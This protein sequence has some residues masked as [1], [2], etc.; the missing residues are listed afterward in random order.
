MKNLR[1]KFQTQRPYTVRFFPGAIPAPQKS[2]FLLID[3]GSQIRAK[4]NFY[5]L[6]GGER[7]KSW[8]ELEKILEELFSLSFSRSNRFVAV[9]GGAVLDLGAMTAS[10]YGRG[11]PLVLVPTTLLAMVDASVGGKTAIDHHRTGVKNFIGT[12]YPAQE[13]WI[14][15]RFLKTLPRRERI[16]G[17]GEC[18]KMIFLFGGEFSWQMDLVDYANGERARYLFPIIQF[19]LEKKISVVEQDPLDQKRIRESLNYGH[20]IGHA[21]EAASKGTLSHGEA[22]LWGMAIESSLA[23]AEGKKI[24]QRILSLAEAMNLK[25]PEKLKDPKVN[26]KKLL[27]RDKKAKG[28]IIEMSVAAGKIKKLKVSPRKLQAALKAFVAEY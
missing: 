28:N 15:P 12:F 3:R 9:G 21:L 25:L 7:N 16:S 13:I 18:L 20:T 6:S 5:L 17:V 19:C 14:S 4:K 1:G 8:K 10:L 27:Q 24:S 23:G 2:D 22:I 26:W 11:M